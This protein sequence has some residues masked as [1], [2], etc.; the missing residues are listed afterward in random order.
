M[1]R[2]DRLRSE[3][4]A[5]EDMREDMRFGLLAILSKAREGKRALSAERHAKLMHEMRIFHPDNQ[6]SDLITNAMHVVMHELEEEIREI[7]ED[8]EAKLV[9]QERSAYVGNLGLAAE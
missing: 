3:L 2:L 8:V 7:E 1:S 9:R 4:T 6:A 5:L